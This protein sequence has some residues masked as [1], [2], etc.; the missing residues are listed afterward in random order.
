[1][2]DCEAC[3]QAAV[4]PYAGLTCAGCTECQVRLVANQPVRVR[5]VF[6]ASLPEETRGDFVRAVGA[7]HR[8]RE[9]LRARQVAA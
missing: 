6:Y 9:A 1:M 5:E 7:E 3:R 4:N 2:S 8:R